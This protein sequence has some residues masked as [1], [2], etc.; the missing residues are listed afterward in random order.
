MNQNLGLKVALIF[1]PYKEAKN[2]TFL[3]ESTIH[4]GKIPPLSLAYV[5]AILEREGCNVKIIDASAM[6]LPLKEI[7]DIL[8]KFNPDFLGFT[9]AT[10][11]F[12]HTVELIKEI[13]KKI[14]KPVIVGGTHVT[15]LPKETLTHP[16]IDY[17]V[18]GD[19]EETLPELLYAIANNKQLNRIKG[20]C[21]KDNGKIIL[22]EK[23]GHF[24]DLDATPFPARDLLPNGLY[25]S[26]ISKKRNFTA[27]ITSRGCPFHCNFCQ[28]AGSLYRFRTAK[29]VV[30]EM[31]EC[32]KKFDINEIDIF[33]E[34]FS[35]NRERVLEIC[36]QI[37]KRRLKVLWSFR[38][39]GDLVDEEMLSLLSKSGCYRIYYGIESGDPQILKN[40]KKEVD[41]ERIKKIVKLTKEYVIQTFGYF[42]IGSP[43]ETRESIKRTVHFMRELP[44]DYAQ[45]APLFT[46]PNT[47]LYKLLRGIIKEDYWAN[48][49][50]TLKEKVLPR[51]GTKMKDDEIKQYTRKAYL[52][53]YLRPIYIIKRIFEFRSYEEIKKSFLAL[54]DITISYLL[55]FLKRKIKNDYQK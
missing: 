50:V 9:T 6:S 44:L 41:L 48:Y 3:E 53:F 33:D 12:R 52:A 24:K 36:N 21:Y 49:T 42:M 15:I 34:A 37:N 18:I 55:G 5:A 39:R 31:E 26:L 16:E 28:S 17:A 13:K 22:T 7:I 14:N 46:P 8:L 47:E 51:F 4:L 30:D 38:T 40:L 1:P 43:G 32:Y 23:R 27:M 25:Y 20:I 2:T 45:I 19:A 10:Y 11:Q 35:F 29:N 54:K